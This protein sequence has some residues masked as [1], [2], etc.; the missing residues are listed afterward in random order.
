MLLWERIPADALPALDS[1][2]ALFT[3]KYWMQQDV[4]S[5]LRLLDVFANPE[6][7]FALRQEGKNAVLV[8][9]K[10]LSSDGKESSRSNGFSAY[11]MLK[12]C[13]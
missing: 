2:H 10:G 12:N 9:V 5:Q 1:E 11:F 3:C 8:S 6:H 13:S 7:D 4:R